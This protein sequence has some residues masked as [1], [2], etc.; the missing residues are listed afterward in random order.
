MINARTRGNGAIRVGLA[1]AN[2]EPLSGFGIE[3]SIPFSGDAIRHHCQ[4]TE[5]ATVSEAAPD[6][7][8]KLVFDISGGEVFGFVVES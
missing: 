5:N 2:G 8:R 6:Q 1:D 3:D 7:Y 4:W